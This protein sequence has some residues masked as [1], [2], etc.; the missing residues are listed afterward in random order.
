MKSNGNSLDEKRDRVPLFG[1]WRN[2]YA[3]VVIAF[4]VEV[5]LFYGMTRFFA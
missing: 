3:T 5:A 1:N 2:A 4:I